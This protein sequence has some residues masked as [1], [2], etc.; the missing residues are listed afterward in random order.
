M[1]PESTLTKPTPTIP[2]KLREMSKQLPDNKQMDSAAAATYQPATH[3][4]ATLLV[5]IVFPLI[6]VGG[7]VTTTD[8]G[9]AVP[10]W[11]NTFGY[12]LFLYP[13]YDWFFGPWDLFVE[14]GH[15]LLASIAGL[16]TLILTVVVARRDTRGWFVILSWLT[17]GM[18][19]LQGLLGGVRV[20]MADVNLAMI[21]GCTGPVYFMLVISM[22]VFSS[23]WWLSN[24]RIQ[25]ARLPQKTSFS[26]IWMSS[27]MLLVC[28]AQLILGANMRHVSVDAS[29]M[30]FQNLI[31]AHVLTAAVIF[32]GSIM[33]GMVCLAPTLRRLGFARYGLGLLLCVTVQI[34]LGVGSWVVKYGLPLGMGSGTGSGAG[35]QFASGFVVAEKDFAQTSIVTA[36]VATGSLILAILTFILCRSIRIRTMESTAREPPTVIQS[37]ANPKLEITT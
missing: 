11:P 33:L 32:I 21:H 10:D 2:L 4:L 22:W 20:L 36:H 13:M 12:N 26:I 37:N 5:L 28:T 31:V 19:L 14:H 24:E 23:R 16:V 7:L 35:S 8:A 27:I 15:R 6:W 1:V 30:F 3:R 18:V 9:M 17:L 29:P 34:G 25:E